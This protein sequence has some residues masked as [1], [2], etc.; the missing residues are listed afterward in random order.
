MVVGESGLGKSTM[1]NTLFRGSV[2]RQSCILNPDPPPTTV[3]INSV[4]HVIEEKSVHLKLSI[5]DTPGFG[6]QIN[7][8]KSWEPIL[9]YVNKQFEIYLNEEV[10]LLLSYELYRYFIFFLRLAL[11]GRNTSQTRV[12][13]A[14][15]TSFLLLDTVCDL[16]TLSS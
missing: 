4:C 1:I 13:T 14:V 12:F 11:T 9:E 6:D 10:S 2:S 16:L 3:K 8:L 7:N 5:T 15:C